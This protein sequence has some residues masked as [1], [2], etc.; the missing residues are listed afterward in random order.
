M[1]KELL[2]ICPLCNSVPDGP[3]S[4]DIALILVSRSGAG[5]QF[6]SHVRPICLPE[7]S[8]SGVGEREADGTWCSVSGWGYQTGKTKQYH[9]NKKP[10]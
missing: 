8:A 1:P 10:F 3:H 7:H 9:L 2:L 4:N 5:V 6:N